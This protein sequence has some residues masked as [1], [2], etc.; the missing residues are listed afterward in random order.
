[1]VFTIGYR[2]NYS[3]F[4]GTNIHTTGPRVGVNRGSPTKS[5]PKFRAGKIPTHALLTTDNN[6]ETRF[7]CWLF[8]TKKREQ[9]QNW[10]LRQ[11][12]ATR[13]TD[14][15]IL[16]A[17][18]LLCRYCDARCCWLTG[19]WLVGWSHGRIAAKQLDGSSCC[20]IQGLP[21]A[22]TVFCYRSTWVGHPTNRGTLGGN[23]HNLPAVEILD[24]R[25]FATGLQAYLCSHLPNVFT[26]RRFH[27][28]SLAFLK[29]NK[30]ISH[31]NAAGYQKLIVLAATNII[32][33]YLFFYWRSR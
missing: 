8:L 27:R 2:R 18:W 10:N 19:R 17:C 4:S 24:T 30:F 7:Q 29:K 3:F 12:S 11:S 1:M 16:A 28:M 6:A 5:K 23:W 32:V 26:T 14:V 21:S 15:H 13:P 22:S 9:T 31:K 25:R 33:A 20:L